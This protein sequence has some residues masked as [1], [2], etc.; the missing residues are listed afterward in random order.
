M[1]ICINSSGR[2][3]VY[4]YTLFL[5]FFSILSFSLHAAPITVTGLVKDVAGEPLIGVAVQVKGTTSG[6]VTDIDGNFSLQTE[7]NA[8]LVFSYMGY[9][10]QSVA[11]GGKKQ[12]NVT[13]KESVAALDEVV[14]VGYGVM[15]KKDLVGAV[16]QIGGKLISERASMNISSSLQGT[17]PGLNISMRDGKPSRGATLNLRGT[18]SI[19]AGGGA[20]IL[21]DGVEGDMT[22]VNPNDVESVSV[23]K[24]AASS[25]I[26]GARAAFG[27]VLITTKQGVKDKTRVT[28]SGSVSGH[29]RLSVPEIVTNGLQFTD[30]WYTAYMEGKDLGIEPGGINNVFPYSKEWYAELQKR[31]ADPTLEKVRVNN[32]GLYEYFGNTD[33]DD[34]MY[35]KMNFSTEHNV[36]VSGGNDRANLYVSGRFFDQDGIYTQGN[37]NYQQYNMRIKG[38]IKIN[39]YLTLDN[40]MDFLRRKIHQPMVMYDRQL[41]PRMVEHQG[42]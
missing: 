15:R 24:D 16:D 38:Q 26:Y 25:A 8:T 36:S 22:T 13:L 32:Q 33:W 11:V 21:I 10:T 31:D 14:V 39:K 29:Q 27:V 7:S 19:G 37:E 41:L 28:Y 4:R 30:G 2:M 1:R 6:T 40:N 23:L 20:L 42:Y 3:C 5:L 18:G 9:E 12:L 35:K 34:I 17:V